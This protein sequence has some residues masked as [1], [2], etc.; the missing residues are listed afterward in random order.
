MFLSF[1]GGALAPNPE[2]RT[3]IDIRYWIPGS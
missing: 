1:R 3:K 2:S